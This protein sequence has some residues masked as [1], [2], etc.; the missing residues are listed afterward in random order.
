MYNRTY[1]SF[2]SANQKKDWV[3]KSQIRKVSYLR[4]FRK[5]SKLFK[6]ANLRLCDLRNLLADRHPLKMR[7]VLLFC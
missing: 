6:S 4:K 2:K 1:G 5:S 7:Q 3:R